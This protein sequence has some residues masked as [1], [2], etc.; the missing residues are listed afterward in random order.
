MNTLPEVSFDP[1]AKL[2]PGAKPLENQQNDV[3][4][5]STHIGPR[6]PSRFLQFGGIM[7][8][9]GATIARPMWS[10]VVGGIICVQMGRDALDDFQ[11]TSLT[12]V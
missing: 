5:D 9:H 1:A 12:P 2:T 8:S 7:R 11:S 4:S 6:W 10:R 3:G